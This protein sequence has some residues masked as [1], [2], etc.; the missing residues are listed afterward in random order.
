MRGKQKNLREISPDSKYNNH[1]IAKFINYIMKGGKKSVAEKIVYQAFDIIKEKTGE[2]P[3]EVFDGAVKNVSPMLEVRGRRIGGANY[4]IP[5]PVRGN[6]KYA[7]AFR[8]IINA[9]EQRKGIPMSKKLALE[10]IDAYNKEGA[11]IKK[12]EDVH[13]MAEANRAFAH[14]AR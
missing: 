2:N 7:L 11:S 8:W 10:L 12:R 14:F 4:Q 6:R 5:Y 3:V 9:A 13:R 1:L